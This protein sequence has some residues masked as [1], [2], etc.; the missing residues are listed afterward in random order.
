MIWRIRPLSC[1][2]HSPN[3]HAFM[4][5]RPNACP[6]ETHFLAAAPY[7]SLNAARRGIEIHKGRIRSKA[8]RK[9]RRA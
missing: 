8:S 3:L 1:R 2:F 6:V 5:L 4:L 9:G 7:V